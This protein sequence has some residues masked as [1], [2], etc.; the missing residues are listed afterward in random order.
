[1]LEFNLMLNGQ[2]NLA[3]PLDHTWRSPR[4][5]SLTAATTFDTDININVWTTLVVKN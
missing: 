2:A 1:M 4:L 5:H 3:V